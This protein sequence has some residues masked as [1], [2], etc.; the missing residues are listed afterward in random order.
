MHGLLEYVILKPAFT[1][2][3]GEVKDN[4]CITISTLSGKLL[5]ST[6]QIHFKCTCIITVLLNAENKHSLTI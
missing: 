3:I 4:I 1:F 6:L 2:L 5:Q